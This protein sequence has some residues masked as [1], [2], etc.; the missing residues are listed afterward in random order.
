[1]AYVVILRRKS[2]GLER[3]AVYSL[4]WGEYSAFM[5]QGGNYECDCNRECLF[6]EAGGE[7]IPDNPACGSSRYALVRIEAEDGT[8]LLAGDLEDRSTR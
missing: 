5:W 2:D 1:M 6:A 8:P 7:P 4:P 3:R